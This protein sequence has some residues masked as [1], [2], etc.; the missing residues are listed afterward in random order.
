RPVQPALTGAIPRRGWPGDPH[1]GRVSFRIQDFS[2]D[3]VVIGGCG[4]VGLPLG[5]AFAD[6]GLRVTLFDI[7]PAA[8][9]RVAAG[10]L[11]FDEPGGAVALA[12]VLGTTLD[13]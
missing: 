1:R 3:V 10:E 13:V 12:R 5:L 2:R 6:R 11:P 7:N 9:A 4:R 8:V